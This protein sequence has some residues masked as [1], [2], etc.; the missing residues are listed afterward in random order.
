MN[1][2]PILTLED[3]TI[4][5]LDQVR[6]QKKALETI[7][8]LIEERTKGHKNIQLSTLHANNPE[9]AQFILDEAIA[10]LP[11]TEKVFAELSPVL[12]THA[13]PGAVGLAYL[14]DM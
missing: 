14:V 5:T 8:K 9:T 2:K 3:G 13:G 11:L 6:T 4:I 12:G 7:V 1:V 10:R